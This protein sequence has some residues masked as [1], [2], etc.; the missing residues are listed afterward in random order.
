[1][2]SC[3]CCGYADPQI[4]RS[5]RWVTDLDY[6]RFEDF[7][8]EYPQWA[9]L[10]IGQIVEDQY[11]FYRRSGKRNQGTYVQRWSKVLGKD[12]Y[13][14]RFFERFKARSGIRHPAQKK[15]ELEVLEVS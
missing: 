5:Y 8:L 6:C 7:Q 3:P 2:R 10:E 11:C 9:N 4:W 13:K 14:S 1:L 12:Y 15:L